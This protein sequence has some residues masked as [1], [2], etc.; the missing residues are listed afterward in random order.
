MNKNLLLTLWAMLSAL[1]IAAYTLDRVSVHDPS[2]VW[3][4][5]SQTYYIFGSHREVAKSTD[6][7]NWTRVAN[8]KELINTS[9]EMR[10]VAWATSSSTNAYSKDAFTTPALANTEVTAVGGVKKSL[11]AFNAQAW[12]EQGAPGTYDITGNLWAPDVIYN[13]EMQKWCMYMSVNGNNWYSSIVLLT[14]DNIEGPYTYQAPIVISGFSEVNYKRTDIELALGSLEALPSRYASPW[15]TTY[16]NNI[17]PCVFYDETGKLRMSY[18]SWFGGIFMLELDEQTGLRDYTVSYEASSTSDPY[19]GK[20]I[21]G[22]YHASGEASYIEYI[23]GYYYLFM[24]YGGFDSNKGYQMRVFRSK[25]PDGPY[26][27]PMHTGGVALY[28]GYRMNYGATAN[29][30]RGENIFGA[31]GSWGYQARGIWGE[32]AQ[33]HNSIIAAQDGHIYLVYHTRFQNRGEGHEVRVHEVFQNEDGWLVAAPFEYTGE[34]LTN[35]QVSTTQQVATAS[36]A[37]HY[38]LMVHR[39]G[40]DHEQKE[41]VTPVEIELKSDGTITGACSGSWANTEGKCYVQITLDGKTYKGVMIN[42]KMEPTDETVVAFTAMCKSDGVSIWGYQFTPDEPVT[43]GDITTGIVAYYNFD[44]T[45]IANFYNDSQVATLQQEGE[46]PAPTLETDYELGTKV[47]H[48]QFGGNGNTSNVKFANPLYGNDNLTDATFAFWVNPFDENRWDALWGLQDDNG[49]RLYLTGNNYLGYNS[50]GW[51]DYNH[52]NSVTTNDITFGIWNFITITISSTQ[53]AKVYVNGVEKPFQ[54]TNS[55]DNTLDY[56][57]LMI[58]YNAL[59]INFIKNCPNMYFGYGSWWGSANAQY[60]ELQ[61]YKRALT[62]TDIKALYQKELADGPYA[63]EEPDY[64]GDVKPNRYLGGDISMLP[65]YEEAGSTYLDKDGKPIAGNMIKYLKKQGWNSMR[66]RLFVDPESYKATDD[67]KFWNEGARQNLADVKAL[68]KRIKDAGMK[69]M[70]DLHY[71]DTWTDPDKHLAP[72]SWE[73][74]NYPQQVYN[75]TK[76]VLQQ[77]VAYG[78]TPDFIQVGNEVN[79]GMLWSSLWGA[80]AEK[81]Y[82]NSTGDKMTN[83]ISYIKSG[84]QACREVCPKAKIVFHVAMDYNA[85]VDYANW[86]AKTWPATLASNSV[87]YDI[88]GLSYYPYYHGSLD[89]LTSLLSYL[90]TNYPTK[91]VQLVEVGYPHAYYPTENSYDYTA[92][93]PA[94]DDGQLTFTKALISALSGYSQVTGLYWWWPEANEYWKKNTSTSVTTNWYNYGLWDNETGK[95]T[96]ALYVLDDFL[97]G[98]VKVGATD[99]TTGYMAATSQIHTMVDGSSIHYTFTQTTNPTENWHGYLLYAGTA[100]ATPT[101]DNAY[102]ILRGDNY[103]DKEGTNSRCKNN[104]NWDTFKTDMNGATVDMYVTYV[105]GTFAMT[106]TITPSGSSNA[107][108]Y[109]YSKALD[110]APASLAVCLSLNNACLTITKDEYEPPYTY[111]NDFENINGSM[112]YNAQGNAI[113]HGDGS[114]ATDSNADFGQVFQN[115][116]NGTRTNYLMLPTDVLSHSAHTKQLTIG[117][118]VNMKSATNFFFSPVFSAYGSEPSSTGNSVPMLVCEARCLVQLNCDGWCDF[119][120]NGGGKTYNDGTPYVT[121]AWLD[122][123]DWHYYTA[124]FTETTAKVYVD[125]E[126]KNGWTVD[127]TS[128]GQKISGLFTSGSQLS[129]I[130]LGGNQAWGW[131]DP[132]PA[133]AFDDVMITNKA[134]TANEIAAIVNS[135]T[136]A[137][138]KNMATIAANKGDITSMINGTFEANAD[139]WTGN[140]NHLALTRSWRGSASNYF[141]ERTTTGTMSYTLS[142]MPAGTYKVVAA[143]RSYAGGQIQPEIASTTGSTMTGVGDGP[144]EGNMEI[145]TN[146]VEMPYSPLGGFT[147]DD[148]GHNWRWISATGTL[149]ADGD[150]TIKFN[151]TGTGWMAIDDVHLYCTNLDGTSYTRTVGDGKGTIN[152]NDYEVTADI[153]MENPNTVLRTTGTVTTAA[154]ETMN[155]NQYNSSRITR[156]V[157]Y[158]GYDFTKLTGDVGADNGAVLYR[159]IP[160]DT[161]NTLVVPFWPTTSLTKKYPTVFANGTLTFSDVDRTTWGGVDKPM[162]IK[163]ATAITA[164]EGK[165]ASTNNGGS[166]VNHNDM[167][168]GAGAPMV[169]VYDKG[170]V[171]VSDATNAYYAVGASDNSL[172]KVT[173]GNVTLKPFRAYFMLTGSTNSRS[174]IGMNFDD[175]APTAIGSTPLQTGTGAAAGTVYNLQGQR[176]AK[177]A[178]GLYIIN[179]KKVMMK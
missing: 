107:Y 124:V 75:Y 15:I 136:T 163:S 102:V 51:I 151:C 120:I 176:V 88:I 165:L 104:F 115:A 36:I 160:A 162:L 164:I 100:D 28:D 99:N 82:A 159:S 97:S 31:Y 101:W 25:N 139:G 106:S 161:W 11:P 63:E 16:P 167:T 81:C 119:D 152:A 121:T 116:A 69:F 45:T 60:D 126:L 86:A 58:K 133:F 155:N 50:G 78:A 41:I 142:N 1:N 73:N 66:V 38:K 13:T 143:A 14:A 3:E 5:T 35:A 47:I 141:I 55:G 7:M 118:W 37:G 158:D 174:I 114:F 131:N 27:D 98:G 48:T 117:F 8:G 90:Q 71:S 43:G 177:P 175:D 65:Y 146:G 20:K 154:G 134:L 46:T 79:N 52:P 67:S 18:G 68:G 156:L 94:T 12:S 21:A 54:S 130:C 145:N 111:F 122:D 138:S 44:N 128:D 144:T 6:M 64:A 93:Y 39:N 2:V 153:V 129:Y 178:K 112:A 23:G 168:S 87:D 166:G 170:T 84:S 83:F 34:T 77:L 19:F 91:E 172:H 53:G 89:Y 49:G 17:D 4:P 95:A 147:T 148:W 110:N 137:V 123:K 173:G 179:G 132:D 113:I 62:D 85:N 29:T 57:A 149:A 33:G 61:V 92:T 169:G 59:M 135:K 103:E 42:Q 30:V 22:G 140:T 80:E 72:Q 171:P 74:S 109:S 76:Y 125:G 24:S 150:L 157:L 127:G 40:L 32:R 108:T 26:E 96:Q 56:N 105:N 10:G 70:L 9:E